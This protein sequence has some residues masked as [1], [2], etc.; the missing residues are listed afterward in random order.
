MTT[1]QRTERR[2]NRPSW[3]PPEEINPETGEI[4]ATPH[5]EQKERDSKAA[6]SAARRVKAFLEDMRVAEE[7]GI[8]RI[9][10]GELVHGR[11]YVFAFPGT[12]EF[13]IDAEV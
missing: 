9:E 11:R 13:Y 1:R 8:L 5:N 2:N 4:Y 3:L 6:K 7:S 10:R 12:P